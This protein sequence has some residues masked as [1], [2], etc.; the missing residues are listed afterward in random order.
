MTTIL[1][2][3]KWETCTDYLSQQGRNTLRRAQEEFVYV[4]LNYEPSCRSWYRPQR[5]RSW[6]CWAAS[7]F[8]CY[9][10]WASSAT[11]SPST[12]GCSWHTT[13]TTPPK[14]AHLHWKLPSWHTS[15]CQVAVCPSPFICFKRK[16]QLGLLLLSSGTL[17]PLNISL[18]IISWVCSL[19][20]W[21]A[22]TSYLKRIRHYTIKPCPW[23]RYR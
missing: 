13:S 1:N 18:G 17:A 3:T 4:A 10:F 8:P 21:I 11:S 23:N 5:A 9:H 12:S 2:V 6:Y 20:P 7:S 15:S 22:I 16:L 19:M 14:P